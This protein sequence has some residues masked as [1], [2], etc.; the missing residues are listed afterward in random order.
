MKDF[1]ESSLKIESAALKRAGE[2]LLDLDLEKYLNFI[3]F[4]RYSPANGNQG[5]YKIVVPAFGAASAAPNTCT[6]I[7]CLFTYA[8]FHLGLHC[9]VHI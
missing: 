1:L 8:A 9:L 2:L 5:Q 3:I 7:L 6:T 4:E